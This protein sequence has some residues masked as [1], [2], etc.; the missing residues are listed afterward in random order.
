MPHHRRPSARFLRHP[1]VDMA[2]KGAV[3]ATAAWVLA[4]RLPAEVREYAFYAPFGAVATMSVAVARSVAE[5][6]RAVGAIMAGAC[7]GL[8]ADRLPGPGLLAVAVAAGAGVIVAG[9]RWFG[10]AGSYVPVA[11][12]FVLL[13][14]RDHEVAYAAS[15]AGLFLLG[16]ACSVAVNAAAPSLPLARADRAIRGLRDACTAHLHELAAT[17]DPVHGDGRTTA[18]PDLTRAL[19][20]AHRAVDDLRQAARANRRTRRSPGAVDERLDDFR[21]L[22]RATL[23]VDD[24]H[25]LSQDAPWGTTVHDVPDALREPMAAA[26]R[27]LAETTAEAGWADT[28]PGRRESAD[29]AVARLAAALR[30]Y[31]AEAGADAVTLVVASVVTTLRRS[32]S[33]VTPD[34]RFRLSTVPFADAATDR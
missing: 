1:R 12:M 24:L 26:L 15:Y 19:D 32:L 23:L 30:A 16:A 21:A 20:D 11:A 31:E 2:V 18:A 7:L 13:L 6:V 27:A 3:A 33:A 4:L 29:R 8:L 5:S 28:E 10:D 17:L 22:R 34:D 9:A 14:G 25:G